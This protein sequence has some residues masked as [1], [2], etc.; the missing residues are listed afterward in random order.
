VGGCC[1][2]GT[3]PALWSYAATLCALLALRA[4]SRSLW[5]VLVIAGK[6]GRR[7]VLDDR[8]RRGAFHEIIDVIKELIKLWH[9]DTILVEPKAAGPDIMD[10]LKEQ[11]AA[12]DVEMVT[13]DECDPGDA[14]RERRLE[15][16]LPYVKNG[17]VFLLDGAPWLAEFVKELA[18]F[19]NGL[20]SDRVDA[21]SQC[22][23]WKR[24]AGDTPWTEM[25]A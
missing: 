2:S 13:I 17:M 1:S 12:G 11:M 4:A 20:Q 3:T 7:F 16:A 5:G 10:T 14:D 21:L 23:N 9:P 8:T 15:A 22:L 24:P 25:S 19:P 18:Q 6:G